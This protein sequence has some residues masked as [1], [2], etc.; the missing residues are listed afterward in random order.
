MS[1]ALRDGAVSVRRLSLFDGERVLT[2]RRRSDVAAQ[3]FS[4]LPPTRAEHY[5]WLCRLLVCRDRIEFLICENGRPVGTVGLSRIDRV[6]QEA[7][8]GILIG[9]PD[10]RGRGVA[11]RA[12]RIALRFAFEVLA[13]TR[14]YLSVFSDNRLA[15][16]LYDRL[17]FGEEGSTMRL[18]D[19][20]PRHVTTMVLSRAAW[21]T[22]KPSL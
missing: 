8:L 16:V 13:M 7:E 9:E 21:S 3:L 20:R 2:W 22:S 19:G 6:A 18:K 5:A 4:A 17:G 14:V 1:V 11:T 15:R 10:A 12:C